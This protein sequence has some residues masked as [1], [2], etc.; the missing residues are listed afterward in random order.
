MPVAPWPYHAGLVRTTAGG[1]AS[2]AGGAMSKFPELRASA[3]AAAAA[4]LA[5]DRLAPAKLMT[6]ALVS[7]ATRGAP[8]Q[9]R[10]EGA[11]G[12]DRPSDEASRTSGVLGRA[13][14]LS[15]KPRTDASVKSAMVAKVYFQ[16]RFFN[17]G[18]QV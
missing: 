2:A 1:V 13:P 10:K 8:E 15:W 6:G 4:P 3:S 11:P 12:R 18:E 14:A 16:G 17:G 7:E 9:R 5:T